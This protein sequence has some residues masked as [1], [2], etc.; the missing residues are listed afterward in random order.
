MYILSVLY[1]FFMHTSAQFQPFGC[2]NVNKV[3]NV[4]CPWLCPFHHRCNICFGVEL[5]A[6]PA[7][8]Y[9]V[10]WRPRQ[11]I[12]ISMVGSTQLW[13]GCRYDW[14]IKFCLLMIRK[15]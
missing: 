13:H 15:K 14:L 8:N 6:S 2:D 12:L 9:A 11:C 1:V 3:Y 10:S 7:T 5:T 4:I